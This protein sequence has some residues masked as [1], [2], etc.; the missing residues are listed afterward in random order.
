MVR[1]V[2]SAAT[3]CVVLGAPRSGTTWMQRLLASSPHVVTPQETHLFKDYLEPQWVRW[4]RH[5]AHLTRTIARL[6]TGAVDSRVIGLPTILDEDDLVSGQV[7]LVERLIERALAAKPGASLVLEKTPSNSLCVDVIDRVCPQARFLHIV[8]DPRDVM[9]SLRDVAGRWAYWGPQSTGDTARTWLNHY[10]GARQAAAL[11]PSR[12]HELRYEELRSNPK[13]TLAEVLDFLGLP[14]DAGVLI[15]AAEA[16]EADSFDSVF[17]FR[18]E[19]ATRLHALPGAEPAGFRGNGR[20]PLSRLALRS[21]E[22]VLGEQARDAG[23]AEGWPRESGPERR[24]LRALTRLQDLQ[25][26]ARRLLH[27]KRIGA[28]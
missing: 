15:E 19:L 23:Y 7:A 13:G 25:F 28:W 5:E 22:A 26:R 6:D 20:R 2:T 8:R 18:P 27:W 1:A 12:Y 14:D 11:G 24:M 3:L 21:A 16:A 4:R 17:A 9:A 10:R